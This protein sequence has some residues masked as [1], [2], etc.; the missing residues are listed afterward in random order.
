MP[1]TINGTTGETTPA[2]VYSG[3]SSGTI[4]VQAPA[5]RFRITYYDGKYIKL[6]TRAD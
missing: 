3:S 6:D 1:V 5:I 2:T 4:T